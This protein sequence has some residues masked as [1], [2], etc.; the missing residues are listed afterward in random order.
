VQSAGQEKSRRIEQ[1]RRGS[2]VS[3]KQIAQA[4]LRG[5]QVTFKF[6][7]TQPAHEI[8]GYVVGMDDYHWLVAIVIPEALREGDQ[9]V[10]LSLV[11]KTADVINLAS[12]ATREHEDREA[13][14]ALASLGQDFWDFCERNYGG[15]NGAP[16][17]T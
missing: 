4:A 7:R 3:D 12:V 11:H 16:R 10:S 2:M 5:R 17:S 9:S 8:G 15:R 14:T 1:R 6:L 13:R